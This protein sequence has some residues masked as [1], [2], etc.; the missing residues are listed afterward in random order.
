MQWHSLHRFGQTFEPCPIARVI[1]RDRPTPGRGNDGVVENLGIQN[2]GE[3]LLSQ[4]QKENLQVVRNL[5]NH[6]A[7]LIFVQDPLDNLVAGS[8]K[9]I[10][11]YNDLLIV[12]LILESEN[13]RGLESFPLESFFS[14]LNAITLAT[15]EDT[16]SRNIVCRSPFAIEGKASWRE[17]I[18]SLH[19]L[20]KEESPLPRAAENN[21]LSAPRLG[22]E[23][24]FNFISYR[25]DKQ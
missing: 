9:G 25:A 14:F 1:G 7:S 15:R 2:L 23:P 4:I 3:A 24:L 11:M 21:Q 16:R 20:R 13:T 19:E 17:I 5:R 10:Q 12:L 6:T 18:Q 8:S 22:Q